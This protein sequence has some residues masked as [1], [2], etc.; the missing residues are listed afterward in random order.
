MQLPWAKPKNISDTEYEDF[1]SCSPTL[2]FIIWIVVDVSANLGFTI[3][4][5]FNGFTAFRTAFDSWYS[6][7]TTDYE[8][9]SQKYHGGLTWFDCFYL[10][11]D[12]RENYY[13]ADTFYTGTRSLV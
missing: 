1:K 11:L 7:M 13:T 3:L 5:L 6:I 8:I 2:R 4:N 9:S 10:E 12:R